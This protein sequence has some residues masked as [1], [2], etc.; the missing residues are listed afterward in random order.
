MSIIQKARIVAGYW[1]VSLLRRLDPNYRKSFDFSQETTHWKCLLTDIEKLSE[2]VR[3][4]FLN[5]RNPARVLQEPLAS[6]IQSLPGP[7]R[8][9]DVGCGPLS[10]VGLWAGNKR[11]E[12][13]GADPLA[14]VYLEL[15]KETGIAPNCELIETD[16]LDLEQRFSQQPFSI[17]TSTNALDHAPKP[18]EVIRQMALVTSRNGYVF[19]RHAENE[20]IRERY[21]G[22]H[23][24]N[25][26]IRRGAPTISDGATCIALTNAIPEIQLLSATREKLTGVAYVEF[27]FQKT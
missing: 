16:C 2:E 8:I 24:W 11:I 4:D 15:L 6:L 10:T 25:F 12:L 13:I 27:L 19:L 18:L 7:W 3:A 20:G 5:R 26:S 1:K 21:N 17:T 9:L 14:R 22:L 23:Q